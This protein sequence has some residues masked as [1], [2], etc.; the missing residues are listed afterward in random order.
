[1]ELH[2]FLSGFLTLLIVT[3]AKMTTKPT[4]SVVVPTR[5]RC[6]TLASTLRTCLEQSYPSLTILVCD[7]CSVDRT[8]AVVA[9]YQDSRLQYVRSPKR[10]SMS[11][12]WEFALQHVTTDYMLV[13]GDDDG[14]VI[15]SLSPLMSYVA[16]NRP[17]AVRLSNITYYWKNVEISGDAQ[18]N[19]IY[20]IRLSQRPYVT[21]SSPRLSELV[22]S[23]DYWGDA[24]FLS[25][26][27]L[28][29]GLFS[30]QVAASIREL[31]QG[32]LFFSNCP[33]MSSAVAAAWLAKEF[34]TFLD[35]VCINGLSRASTGLSAA[36]QKRSPE[37]RAFFDEKPIP[38][39]PSIDPGP[40]CWQDCLCPR[41]IVVADQF[42]K[43]H[44]LDD[45]FSAPSIERIIDASVSASLRQAKSDSQL[46][47]YLS[48]TEHVAVKNDLKNVY[49]ESC[50]R[51]RTADWQPPSHSLTAYQADWK[52][53]FDPQSGICN[54]NGNCFGIQDV[55]D[56]A[57]LVADIQKEARE[58]GFRRPSFADND[59]LLR[60]GVNW[61]R[62]ALESAF[63]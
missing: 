14:L 35:P 30:R 6:D 61:L 63:N 21:A 13:L 60:R 45:N 37:F 59:S 58:T 17:S 41:P 25:L 51:L 26:P 28:Y 8:R 52:C 36:R 62:Q 32:S 43:L 22:Q 44:E 19:G 5:D 27:S 4:V 11:A 31:T 24:G 48:F 40:N 9:E 10:L 42:L 3:I 56:V 16:E 39:H 46:A 15:D 12:N 20:N 18:P 7:N 38:F 57:K 2:V 29:H 33:D 1:M 34:H 47:S 54:I 23:L 55:Y 50:L 49:T 53:K